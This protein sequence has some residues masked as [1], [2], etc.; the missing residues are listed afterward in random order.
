MNFAANLEYAQESSV[1]VF[2]QNL[3]NS[4]TKIGAGIVWRSKDA[5]TYIITCAHL[6]NKGTSEKI[7]VYPFGCE[8][9]QYGESAELIGTSLSYDVALLRIKNSN[10]QFVCAKQSF[11]EKIGM[12][13]F[14]LGNPY[15]K[16]SSISIGI[17]S[18]PYE[19]I[20]N[21][22][23]HRIDCTLSPGNS[24][25]GIYDCE[26]NILGMVT[27]KVLSATDNTEFGY[28]IP[29]STLDILA[30]K[31]LNNKE[32]SL[33]SGYVFDFS[34]QI[35]EKRKSTD[36]TWIESLAIT[37]KG[38]N[39]LLSIGDRIIA[40]F[41]DEHIYPI[42]SKAQLSILLMDTSANSRISIVLTHYG[43]EKIVPINA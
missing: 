6:F 37:Q 24:G 9:K 32:E 23:L 1:S 28:A 41:V 2:V 42:I 25:G 3:S 18:L 33:Q 8:L 20:D 12:P 30:N 7:L 34:F 40:I 17:L 43:E 27:H 21:M 16:G 36:G 5:D 10:N 39:N 38:N 26:G 4:D 14:A 22:F 31:I 35:V 29:F 11:V 13:I 15:G 19:E